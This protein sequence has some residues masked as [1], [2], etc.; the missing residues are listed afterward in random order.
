MFCV[1]TV[2]F[3]YRRKCSACLQIKPQVSLL[4]FVTLSSEWGGTLV[5]KI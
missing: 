1:Q 2:D 4:V 5:F 3:S